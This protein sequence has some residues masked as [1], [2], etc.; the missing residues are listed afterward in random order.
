MTSEPAARVDAARLWERHQR[1]ARHGATADG[2]VNRQALSAE[3]IA[4]WRELVGWAREA[5]LAAFTDPAGNLFLRLEGSDAEAAP[6]L[7]GSHLDSQP[8]GG[9]FDGVFGV[10]AGLEA[11]QSIRAAGIT[12]RRPLEIVAWMNEEGSRFVPGMMGS[13]AFTGATPLDTFLPVRDAAGIS[14]REGLAALHGAF[15]DL[16]SRPLGRPVAAY[17]EAHIEQGP[18]LEREGYTI[19]IVTGIQGKRT[20]RVTVRG[21]E[22][23]AG[24]T[25]PRER[26]DALLAAVRMIGALDAAMRDGDDVVKFT[27]GRLDVTP[28]AP[29][30]VAGTAVFSID[31]RHVDSAI[32][33]ALGD[34]IAGICAAHAGGCSVDVAE[35]TRASSLAFPESMKRLVRES[36][37]ALGVP[38]MDIHS[39][40]GHD[41]RFLHEVCPTGMIFVPC[42]DGIS[43]NARESATPEDLAAGARV[44]VDVLM[45]L[46]ND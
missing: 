14:V 45:K 31:L 44:L 6:V 46:A 34:R 30:V 43:H 11:A 10:L 13:A 24:T 18:I 40:A 39:A 17:V 1:L 23:H 26:K 5:G 15:P 28:N 12:L 7:T 20:F 4:A 42:K 16:P 27:V 19:G 36:A 25:T 9:K 33:A 22:A 37:A 32:L 35:L 21:E 41:A 3:E 38:A 2:G 29:S 8:S